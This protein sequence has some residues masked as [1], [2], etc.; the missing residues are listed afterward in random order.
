MVS[1]A[2]EIVTNINAGL[3]DAWIRQQADAVKAVGKPVMI[4]YLWEMDLLTEDSVSPTQFIAAW[5]RIHN[6]FE[7]RGA[8]NARWVWCPSAYS[9]TSG[10]AA[11]WYPGDEYV[12]WIGADGYNWGSSTEQGKWRSFKDVFRDFY[13][14]GAA[15][16]KPLLIGET[17]AKEGWYAGQKGQWLIDM[18]ETIKIDY[19]K[20][21]A[22]VMFDANS[23]DFSGAWHDW[24]LD[25]S[26]SA[27]DAWKRLGNDPYFT[28]SHNI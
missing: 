16:N 9:F 27:F 18:G 4:R 28:S 11:N 6:I 1:W 20:I 3:E 19:P 15:R 24:R 5:R 22:L 2:S 23:T 17:G 21:K 7:A 26:W 12:D 25:S 13:A 10:G 14:W 8:T